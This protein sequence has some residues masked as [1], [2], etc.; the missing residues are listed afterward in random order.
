MSKV[1]ASGVGNANSSTLIA[2]AGPL[3]DIKAIK[4]TIVVPAN[5]TVVAYFPGSSG[6]GRHWHDRQKKESWQQRNLHPV[7][8]KNKNS[9]QICSRH[10]SS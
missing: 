6:H 5:Q 1:S 4:V 3:A 8:R 2:A 9:G 7:T 10:R